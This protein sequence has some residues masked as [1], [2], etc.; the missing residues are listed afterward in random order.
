MIRP[1][2]AKDIPL[3]D[4]EEIPSEEGKTTTGFSKKFLEGVSKLKA[5][6]NIDDKSDE[7][8]LKTLYDAE[9]INI[10]R[11]YNISFIMIAHPATLTI[12]KLP[13][14]L[15]VNHTLL[16]MSVYEP[17]HFY[18]YYPDIYGDM[19]SNILSRNREAG[20]MQFRIQQGAGKKGDRQRHKEEKDQIRKEARRWDC[21]KWHM[22]LIHWL[23]TEGG[24]NYTQ[25][26]TDDAIERL[27]PK[28]QVYEVAHNWVDEHL[29]WER[30]VSYSTSCDLGVRE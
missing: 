23:S 30:E 1:S 7:E 12:N 8:F 2:I 20:E 4:I 24:A 6:L 19:Q 26:L 21:M 10:D 27:S 28:E 9:I 14:D 29:E 17:N 16:S 15:A 3:S 18:A 5:K 13:A 25:V 22:K 11:M